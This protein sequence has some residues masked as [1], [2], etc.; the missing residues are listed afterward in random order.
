MNWM[1]AVRFCRDNKMVLRDSKLGHEES[2]FG[3]YWARTYR[4]ESD[5]MH[6]YGQRKKKYFIDSKKPINIE[7]LTKNHFLGCV[8]DK[9]VKTAEPMTI[10]ECL[11]NCSHENHLFAV[12]VSFIQVTNL[13]F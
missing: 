8:N 1:D 7:Q 10:K 3:K 9:N 6:L 4:R 11:M 13:P 2:M 5:L 12:N